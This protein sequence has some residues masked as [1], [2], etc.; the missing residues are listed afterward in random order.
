MESPTFLAPRRGDASAFIWISK[1]RS[2]L[3]HFKHQRAAGPPQLT[4]GHRVTVVDGDEIRDFC[5]DHRETFNNWLVVFRPTPL[6]N[7]GVKVSFV[8]FVHECLHAVT[9][10]RDCLLTSQF[11]HIHPCLGDH[12]LVKFATVYPPGW[13]YFQTALDVRDPSTSCALPSTEKMGFAYPYSLNA[14]L[15]CIFSWDDEIPNMMGKS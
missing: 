15:F 7:H 8:S 10:A 6:K 5:W 4:S 1:W 2:T 11:V 12:G 9:W 3:K 14:L 13:R